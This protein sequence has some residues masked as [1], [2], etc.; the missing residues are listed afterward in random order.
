[1]SHSMTFHLDDDTRHKL[2]ELAERFPS[3]SAAVAA[4]IEQ[5]WRELRATRLCVE[6]AAIAADPDDR[7]EM[8]T[9]A[10]DMAP[11]SAW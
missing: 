10:A 9:V 5:A 11:L 3:R 6:S 2:A 4:A 7:A 8:R 1:M